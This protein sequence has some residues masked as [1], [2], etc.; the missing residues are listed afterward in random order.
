[1]FA[2]DRGPASC[3]TF[4]DAFDPARNAFAFLRMVLALLVIVCH[5]FALGVGGNDPL[6]WITEG[7]HSLGEIAVAIF[8]LLSG[9][10][11]T[12][13]GLR[14]R[15]VG[16]F[17]WHRFLRIFPGYWVCLAVTA[18]LFSALFELIKNGAF[19]VDPDAAWAYLRGNWAMFH[20]N[21]FSIAGVMNLRP[22]TIGWVLNDNPHPWGINGSLWSLP[23]ECAC[24]LTLGLFT[25]VGILRRGRLGIVF[26]YFGLWTLYAFSCLDPEYFGE[27]FPYRMFQP[28]VLL[29]LYFSAGC[30]CYLYRESIPA[31]KALFGACLVLLMVGL[32]FGSFGLVAPVAMSYV[33]MC[34]AFWL[35]IRRFDAWG[36]F[37]YGLYIYAFPVQQG[38]VLLH[39]PQSGFAAFF[40]ATV[41]I[42]LV[43]AVWSYHCI[44]APSLRLKNYEPSRWRK[45]SPLSPKVTLAETPS[46]SCVNP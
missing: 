9:F 26:L 23:Y 38:L 12:R 3:P 27:C 10:L 4:A 8:F 15:S 11:I 2:S 30:A 6:G 7:R 41:L 14:S 5:C 16:R 24:Y 17:L 25:F 32:A 44:E 43:L 37:S 35:P 19:S 39:V 36:D 46:R 42:T 34:L 20:L 33:F 29:T 13:S 1:M 28:L 40:A 31:S 45:S 21:G 22:S 18:F